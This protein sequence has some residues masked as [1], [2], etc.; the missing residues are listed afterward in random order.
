MIES[1]R[2][3]G[4]DALSRR[5]E[6]IKGVLQTLGQEMR[7]HK[8]QLLAQA[9]GHACDAQHIVVSRHNAI[10]AVCTAVIPAASVS[11]LPL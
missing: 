7:D 8:D 4:V 10:L 1:A 5:V 2:K 6:E 3:E 9:G 11:P